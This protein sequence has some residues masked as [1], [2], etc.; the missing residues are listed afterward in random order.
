MEIATI[1]SATPDFGQAMRTV[2]A[3][4]LVALGVT[5]EIAGPGGAFGGELKPKVLTA[6]QLILRAA[7]PACYDASSRKLTSL[8]DPAKNWA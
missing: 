6:R 3:D 2:G 7:I 5:R 4:S 1:A 8:A